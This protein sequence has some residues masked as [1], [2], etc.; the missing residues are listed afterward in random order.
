MA[1]D[2][3]TDN[4][5]A[6]LVTAHAG[7]LIRMALTY[8][9][10]PAEAARKGLEYVMRT[11]GTPVDPDLVAQIARGLLEEAEAEAVEIGRCR[12]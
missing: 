7:R 6:H 5:K 8:G 11:V 4:I 9:D 10:P 12:S 3:L 1:L 2:D